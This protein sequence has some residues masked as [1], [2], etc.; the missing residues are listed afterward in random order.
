M[1]GDGSLINDSDGVVD[2]KQDCCGKWSCEDAAPVRKAMC[3]REVI[4]GDPNAQLT[5]TASHT[6]SKDPIEHRLKLAKALNKLL[7]RWRRYSNSPVEMWF[8]TEAHPG[9]GP[10]S[11]WPHIHA[12]VRAKFIPI[13]KLREWWIELTGSWNIGIT[14]KTP[15]E[16]ANYVTKYLTKDLHKYGNCRRYWKTRGYILKKEKPVF[17]RENTVRKGGHPKIWTLHYQR[18]GWTL[19]SQ[20]KYRDARRLVE[21]LPVTQSMREG[22]WERTG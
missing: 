21:V 3:R 10:N 6:W 17:D 1:C 9:D 14:A 15:E 20:S 7:K 11:G 22:T 4:D 18:L 19:Y 8:S 5:A 16:I 2:I 12:A 13:E